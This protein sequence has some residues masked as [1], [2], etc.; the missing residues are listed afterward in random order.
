MDSHSLGNINAVDITRARARNEDD[1]DDDDD[2]DDVQVN[3][4][5][6]W[7]ARATTTMRKERGTR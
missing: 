7:I 3:G 2:D 1:D 6:E 5:G 4:D